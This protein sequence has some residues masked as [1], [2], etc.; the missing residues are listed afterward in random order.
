MCIRDRH[1]LRS[2]CAFCSACS[3]RLHII[4]FHISHIYTF[5]KTVRVEPNCAVL[6]ERPLNTCTISFLGDMTIASFDVSARVLAVF[7][8][9]CSSYLSYSQKR[10][11]HQF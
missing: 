11:L 1:S 9:D 2:W 8:C 7:E 10:R 3:T 4:Q 5:C 6:A